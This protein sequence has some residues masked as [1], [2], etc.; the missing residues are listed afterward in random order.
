MF[1]GG[2]D[3]VEL[4]FARFESSNKFGFHLLTRNFHMANG[5]NVIQLFYGGE[6]AEGNEFSPL[7]IYCSII[8]VSIG[9]I[10]FSESVS[11]QAH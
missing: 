1:F 10:V 3:L 11:G 5:I 7:P 2:F 9:F 4:A 8:S 6:V